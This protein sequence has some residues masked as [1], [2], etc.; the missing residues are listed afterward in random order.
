MK[1]FPSYSFV[2]IDEVGRGALAG[3]VIACAFSWK[4]KNF[5]NKNIANELLFKLN[6][7]KQLTKKS[8]SEL[9]EILITLG[10]YSL[11][12]ASVKEIETLNIL[13]A[14]FLAMKR[15]FDGLKELVKES[16]LLID[17][18]KFN[19]LINC[20]Q[21]ALVDGDA[22]SS[23]IAAA[24]I[25]AKV[26]RDSLMHKLAK[27][28]NYKPFHWGSNVGYGTLV[29]RKAIKKYGLTPLHRKLFVRKILQ[30]TNSF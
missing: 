9:Y 24:S 1:S 5:K 13:N 4:R 18:N 29:H 27:G 19:P 14:T 20:K 15:A 21:L 8:R 28:E 11:G 6:D 22:N 7:S 30:E 2:G 17:G 23:V 10:Y 26:Y 12:Y 16:Y 3:P 25:V